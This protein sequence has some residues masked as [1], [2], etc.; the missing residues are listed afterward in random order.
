MLGLA[1]EL[2]Q[3]TSASIGDGAKVTHDEVL[4]ADDLLGEGGG[5]GG[6]EHHHDAGDQG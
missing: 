1:N 6:E 5:H 4:G 2:A 3:E